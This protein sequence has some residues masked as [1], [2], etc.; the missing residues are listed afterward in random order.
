MIQFPVALINRVCTFDRV[1]VFL[2]NISGYLSIYPYGCAPSLCIARLY[3][4]YLFD[5][6]V[7]R[8]Q[9]TQRAKRCTGY[10]ALYIKFS[11][12]LLKRE[13]EAGFALAN[14]GG[15]CS[16]GEWRTGNIGAHM[17]TSSRNNYVYRRAKFDLPLYHGGCL[18]RCYL[19]GTQA[20][21]GL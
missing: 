16:S 8:G 6:M 12:N 1:N 7:M 11:L 4:S 9:E 5:E 13:S 10:A 15:I 3:I 19:L 17:A 21:Y 18:L 2:K 14:I 20:A